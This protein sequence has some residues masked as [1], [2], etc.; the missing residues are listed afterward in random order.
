MDGEYLGQNPLGLLGVKAY[1]ASPRIPK[2]PRNRHW[3]LSLSMM[4]FTAS[5]MGSSEQLWWDG[6]PNEFLHSI[7]L[8]KTTVILHRP[9]RY[10]HITHLARLC[11]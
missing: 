6:T 10:T 11:H 9:S 3:A 4:V 7:S 8:A 1:L 2:A 5:I